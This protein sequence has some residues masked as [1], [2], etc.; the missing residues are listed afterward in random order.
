MS[1]NP[2]ARFAADALD[3]ADKLV[4]SGDIYARDGAMLAITAQAQLAV[5]HELRTANLIALFADGAT[6]PVPGIE[7][8]PLIATIKER[9]GL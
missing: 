3:I 7:Y 4:A 6:G 5:A 8:D 1:G 9:L 2:H